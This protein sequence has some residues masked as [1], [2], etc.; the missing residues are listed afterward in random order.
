MNNLAK[1]ATGVLAEATLLLED[2]YT[3]GRHPLRKPMGEGEARNTG[4]CN[5][6]V[7]TIHKQHPSPAGQ[8]TGGS[9]VSA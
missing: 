9:T 2:D 7:E 8:L 5:T 3:C 1:A 4:P 6:N